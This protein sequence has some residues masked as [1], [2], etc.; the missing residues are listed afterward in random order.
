MAEIIKLAGAGIAPPAFKVDYLTA[1]LN[2]NFNLN[3]FTRWANVPI[4]DPETG[5]KLGLHLPPEYY[6]LYYTGRDITTVS[7]FKGGET[8]GLQLANM[9]R[10]KITR[11]DVAAD[12]PVATARDVQPALD[13]LHNAIKSYFDTHSYKPTVHK[14]EG[15]P[16]GNS[17]GDGYSYWS[18]N[19]DRQLSQYG[20]RFEAGNGVDEN[21]R[22]DTLPTHLEEETVPENRYYHRV[23]IRLKS[24]KAQ[25][26]FDFVKDSYPDSTARLAEAFQ[27]ALDELFE[28][29]LFDMGL[30][31][32]FQFPAAKTGREPG[33][34]KVWLLTQVAP[35]IDSH[36]RETGEDLLPDLEGEVMALRE[37]RDRNQK[38]R[39]EKQVE[40]LQFQAE[41]KADRVRQRQNL[42][43]SALKGKV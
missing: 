3:D 15:S 28:P 4:V 26:L 27:G 43:L 12:I 1:R 29:G 42:L 10:L 40:R 36:W 20:K 5:E 37:L 38:F 21:G 32:E 30:P 35:A 41:E 17:L 7:F 18:R 9:Y 23:E 6:K 19:S 16:K 8:L 24:D 13:A 11:I 31:S 25:A 34:R 2:D 14:W 22:D 39:A 33:A